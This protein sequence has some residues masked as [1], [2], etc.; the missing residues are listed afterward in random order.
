MK[1]LL[2]FLLLFALTDFASAQSLVTGTIQSS[3]FTC[4]PQGGS[5]ACVF[6][7]VAPQTNSADITVAGTYSGTLQFEVSGDGGA[8]WV[9]VLATPPGSTS[10]VT[11]TTSTG[12]WTA[13]MAGHTFIRV[14]A[15][16]LASGVASITLN[17][18]QAV[19]ASV[20]SG[21]GGGSGTVTEVNTGGIA[22]G[23]PF[24]TSG[25]VTVAGSGNTTTAVTAN[26]NF[27]AA[28][29]G[30]VVTTDG[31]GNGKD[32]GTL[33][34]QAAV[35]TI[36][37][38]NQGMFWSAG[39]SSPP[40]LAAVN[41]NPIVNQTANNVMAFQFVLH[42][43]YT[44]GHVIFAAASSWTGSHFSAAIYNAAGTTKLIDSGAQTPSSAVKVTVALGSAVTLS[45]GVYWF[46]QT[47]DAATSTLQ[48]NSWGGTSSTATLAFWSSFWNGLSANPKFIVAGNASAAGVMPSSLGTLTTAVV[49][50]GGGTSAP[51][52]IVVGFE[53]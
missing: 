35:A 12:T 19:T 27:A 38:A 41:Q 16:A 39:L 23:G 20:S 52:M 45:P 17:P 6:L 24:S 30:D 47:A 40:F 53:P 49:A 2:L 26:A 46:A 34:S 3:A 50:G 22:T 28:P 44:I 11:S 8:T 4:Q 1:K 21:G 33:L 14:R 25:T 36:A 10:A 37:T 51:G 18:S 29:L 13:S 31:A 42:D 32:S 48:L 15:S 43:T 9:S 5:T 7:Q